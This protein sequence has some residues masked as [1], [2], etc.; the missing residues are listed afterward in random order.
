MS[1]TTRLLDAWKKAKNIDSDN[2]AAITLGLT[3]SA[4]SEWRLNGVQGRAGV[5]ARMAKDLSEDEAAWLALIESERARTDADRK[6]WAAV[7]RRLGAVA[8]AL[9]LA[10]ALMMPVGAQAAQ[11]AKANLNDSTH[12]ALCEVLRE[13]HARLRTAFRKA[14]P[15]RRNYSP[16]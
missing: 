5:I 4:V 7:A 6:A 10:I 12:Y 3:R 9:V 11:T 15:L 14:L 13:V 2:A 8:A 16:L 1:A